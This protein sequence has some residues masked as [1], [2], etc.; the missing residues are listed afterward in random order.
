MAVEASIAD[1][2][3][4]DDSTYPITTTILNLNYY[5]QYS[6]GSNDNN[7]YHTH[8]SYPPSTT[9][10]YM[11][12]PL[13]YY[14]GPPLSTFDSVP[15]RI[16]HRSSFNNNTTID[17]P[18]QL[19]STTTYNGSMPKARSPVRTAPTMTIQ[20]HRAQQMS[21]YN[22]ISLQHLHDEPTTASYD[23]YQYYMTNCSHLLPSG[24]PTSYE[25][26]AQCNNIIAMSG[27]IGVRLEHGDLWTK[28]HQHTTE[29][30]ITKQGR[31]MFPTLQFNIFGLNPDS[32]YNLYVDMVLVDTNHWKFNSGKWVPCG[33]AE[34]CQKSNY[35]Y[36]HPDSPNTGEH[37]M[38]NEISFS[39]LKLTNN[40][41]ISPGHN[42]NMTLILNS[43]HK[44]QPR[45]HI[46]EVSRTNNGN[47]RCSSLEQQARTGQEH[48]FF[49]AETQF[50][51]VTAYQNTDVT[52]LKIDHNPFAKV[53]GLHNDRLIVSSDPYYHYQSATSLSPHLSQQHSPQSLKNMT[54]CE[55][56]YSTSLKRKMSS[57][58]EQ[59]QSSNSTW[60]SDNRQ[61]KRNKFHDNLERNFFNGY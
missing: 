60:L 46:V 39:K 32:N 7:N 3:N 10:D 26:P 19:L 35:V 56:N 17:D 38:K 9:N 11:Y 31:R 52:Q 49:F 41:S 40:R 48:T 16:R 2:I 34:Q 30:I 15:K 58:T 59:Q 4:S 8:Q 25:S 20:Q 53:Y 18:K 1:K 28:F 37:W 12:P 47:S 50:I 61:S 57:Y 27:H 5:P 24:Q 13:S 33:Q 55:A 21:C 22:C 51:A 29:M 43:M 45:L 44:Y 23:A 42:T 14:T 36:I 54:Y 6:C